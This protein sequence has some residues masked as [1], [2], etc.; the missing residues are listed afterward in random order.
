MALTFDPSDLLERAAANEKWTDSDRDYVDRIVREAF[1]ES[2]QV[3]QIQRTS[4]GLIAYDVPF[5]T[6]QSVLFAEGH[7]KP[8]LHA[9]EELSKQLLNVKHER[10]A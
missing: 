9:L 2:F 1:E 6:F 4:I 8:V 7:E 10:R 5:S 3:K